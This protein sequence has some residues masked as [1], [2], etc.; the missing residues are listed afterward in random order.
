MKK[1]FQ[2]I[3]TIIPQAIG[4]FIISLTL[5]ACGEF[6]K[7]YSQDLVLPKTPTDLDEILV[8]G[9][10]GYLPSYEV[11]DNNPGVIGGWFNI[12]DDD[13]NGVV[14]HNAPKNWMT[15]FNFYFGYT[16]WQLEVGRNLNRTRLTPDNQVW[17][18]LYH[19]INSMNMILH[20]LTKINIDTE[21]DRLKAK[22]IEGECHFLR[23][24]FYF[25]LV[26]LYGKA[27]TPQ[28]ADVDL[29]VPLKLTHYVEHDRNKELQF[30]RASVAKIYQQIL[31]DLHKAIDAFVQSPQKR[32]QFRA[33]Q[34]AA[35]LLLSRVQLYMQ[36]WENAYQTANGL[37]TTTKELQNLQTIP[38]NKSVISA[39]NPEILFSQ[40]SLSIQNA[41]AADGGDFCV[42]NDLY[43]LFDSN[44]LRY[45]LYFSKNNITDS[46]ALHRK[47]K[48]EVHRSKVSDAFTLRTA[49]IY[50]NA[51]E[52]AAESGKQERA[53]EI[54]SQLMK[55]RYYIVP[56]L[57]DGEALVQQIREERRKELCFEGH[58]WF[59]LRRYATNVNHPF[60]KE[61]LRYFSIYD[62]ENRTLYMNTR[63]Y[64]LSIDDDA[65]VFQIPQRLLDIE[66]K[67]IKN[68]RQKREFVVMKEGNTT[69]DTQ[70]P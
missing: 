27:Y 31:A 13:L 46:I 66:P 49:E 70:Q 12:L 26:N 69:D 3:K 22:R 42:S 68:P 2:K 62:N 60:K 61:I 17:N 11:K 21:Q 47:Y 32:P 9:A 39:E 29:A 54:L 45:N 56:T 51:A 16:T 4:I 6:L 53:K 64:T 40:G 1:I 44:D 23:A 8:G 20:Q 30:Q 65:Y 41:F 48:M 63:I 25:T 15:M 55:E 59:D 24:Q 37:L 52:A 34:E 38:E 14:A 43:K 28:T 67:Q 19:R 7:E 35:T 50:L 18:D 33:S 58:R 36:D 5:N 57:Q 10:D